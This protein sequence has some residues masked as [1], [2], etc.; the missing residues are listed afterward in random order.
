VTLVIVAPGFAASVIPVRRG[1]EQAIDVTLVAETTDGSL[2]VL[3]LTPE[4]RP[5]AGARAFLRRTGTA[6]VEEG[7]LPMVAEEDARAPDRRRLAR[8]VGG[9]AIDS[10]GYGVAQGATPIED[11]LV[12]ADGH[13]RVPA[14]LPGRYRLRAVLPARPEGL[15]AASVDFGTLRLGASLDAEVEVAA[16]PTRSAL[17]LQFPSG[18]AVEG[19]IVVAVNPAWH[20]GRHQHHHFVRPHGWPW[21]G[22]T[23]E[24]GGGRTGRFRLE[25]MPPDGFTL[26][27]W[28]VDHGEVRTEVPT[29]PWGATV[30][31]V[32]PI[33]P[34]GTAFP[35][36]SGAPGLTTDVGDIVVPDARV[37]FGKV[38]G[39]D[40]KDLPS[41]VLS[42]FGPVALHG[43]G[44]ALTTYLCSDGTFRVALPTPPAEGAVLIVGRDR[45]HPDAVR[46][47]WPFDLGDEAHPLVVPLPPDVPA[48]EKAADGPLREHAPPSTR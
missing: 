12:G 11:L 20:C 14:L 31:V 43:A 30:M 24:S 42:W 37:L 47:P 5:A 48:I 13:L 15:G 36:A 19:R 10:Q 32:T 35:V 33:L 38:V 21:A 9:A 41:N 17:T 27:V 2:D 40:G 18:R 39:A 44:A 34:A 45:E 29:V 4:G 28:T 46:V 8:L 26:H 23:V 16:P 25:G 22:V 6:F 1:G 3:L 7:G